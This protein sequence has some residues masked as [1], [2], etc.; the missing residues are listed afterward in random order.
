MS[1]K[2]SKT[3]IEAHLTFVIT[4]FTGVPFDHLRV[5]ETVTE[6]ELLDFTKFKY[7]SAIKK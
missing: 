3:R 7:F 5:K 2:F 6:K 4:N 1:A